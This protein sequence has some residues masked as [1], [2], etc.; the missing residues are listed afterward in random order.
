MF[1]FNPNMPDTYTY[2]PLNMMR[3]WQKKWGV[4]IPYNEYKKWGEGDYEVDLVTEFEPHEM[5]VAECLH[6]GDS[7][8]TIIL[9]AHTCHPGQINDGISGCSLI[10]K[11]FNWLEGKKTHYT[12]RGVLA[13]EHIGTVFYLADHSPR[14]IKNMKLGIFLESVGSDTPLALQQTFHGNS[15]IDKVAEYVLRDIDPDLRLGAFRTVVGNDETVWEAAGIEVPMVSITRYPFPEYHS[16][17]DNLMN[18]S[19]AKLGETLQALLRMVGI[20]EGDRTIERKFTGL[21]ALSN[22]KFD[23]YRTRVNAAIDHK[24]TQSDIR[25]G[26]LQDYLPRYFDNTYSIFGIAR[27]AQVEFEDLAEYLENF[28]KKKLV[29]LNK[30]ESIDRYPHFEEPSLPL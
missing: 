4:C 28:Q 11:L 16:S 22:P 24:L 2:N 3:P 14:E 8:E 13:P 27:A 29:A 20:L 19:T 5:L 21:I 7:E 23:L 25:W 15:I 6:E 9:N 17:E 26:I 1:F 10:L 18:Q 30:I 12:Y